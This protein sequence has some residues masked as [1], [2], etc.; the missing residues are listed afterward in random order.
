LM[1]HHPYLI[2]EISTIH[3]RQGSHWKHNLQNPQQRG[4]PT[5][6]KF[7]NGW[8]S[9]RS[10]WTT[11]PAIVTCYVCWFLLNPGDRHMR[12]SVNSNNYEIISAREFPI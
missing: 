8:G 12:P 6:I 10:L 9:P 2:L 5:N 3:P 4:I 1:P 11:V 7:R